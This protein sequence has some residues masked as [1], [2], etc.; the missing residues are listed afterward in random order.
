LIRIFLLSI[1]LIQTPLV[2]AKDKIVVGS[3]NFIESYILAEIIAL[4]IEKEGE[5][6]VE[7]KFGLGGTG[8]IFEALKNG[9]IDLYPEYSG[10][11]EKV[12]LKQDTTDIPHMN[13]LLSKHNLMVN[14]QFKLNNTYAL[15]LTEEKFKEF[16]ITKISQ[17]KGR[18]NIAT[19]FT[20]EFIKREDGLNALQK[21]YQFKL[22]NIIAM[23]HA[24]A[25]EAL[26]TAKV[27]MIEVY[28]T[29]GKIK[30]L[31]LKILEDDRSFF[32]RYIG[33][34]LANKDIKDKYP[35]T[36]NALMK[37]NGKI[38][39][40]E[41]TNLNSMA[42]VYKIPYAVVAKKYFSNKTEN[43]SYKRQIQWNKIIDRTIEHLKLVF[44]SCL[45][46]FII[47]VP[48]GIFAYLSNSFR[49]PVLLLVGAVQT[50][51]SL[52]LL[53]FL[54]P[55]FGIGVFPSLIALF[56]YGLLP[57][58]RGTYSGLISIDPLLNESADSLGLTLV[59]KL[60]HIKLPLAS[61]HIMSGIK[62]SA[63][64]SVG[65]ATLA[66][67]I[68]AG[69]LG[70]FIMTGLALN[71]TNIILQGAIPATMLSFAAHVFFYILDKL[72]IPKGLRT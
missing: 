41:M 33:L 53:C 44:I 16:G 42:E 67:L 22:T 35:R 65:T 2:L 39:T 25:Y 3:K 21:H 34:I 27:Q 55:L 24:L 45:F 58:V 71:D 43:V 9:N 59:Q 62:T 47:G 11:I 8:I 60:Q 70:T 38:D 28:S 61:I 13:S 26:E 50:I 49:Q 32:P 10:T 30:K 66:A 48:L 72:I 6:D 4:T 57:I 20:H 31:N 19:A 5:V 52:A 51:P 14:A 40:D 64:I 18:P 37:L 29:D 69:G 7:R 15:A 56:L 23:E 12:I 17:L 54:I 46:S 68:G 1:I 63:V 36:W